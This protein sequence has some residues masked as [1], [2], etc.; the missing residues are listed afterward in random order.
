MGL[1]GRSDGYSAERA[2]YGRKLARE[3]TKRGY[4][5]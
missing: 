4:L 3:R 1:P 2:S 5:A